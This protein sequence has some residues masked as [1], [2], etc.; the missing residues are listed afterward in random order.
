MSIPS[1]PASTSDRLQ[2][3]H[4]QPR[5]L[6]VSWSWSRQSG[7]KSELQYSQRPS[8]G[9]G[10]HKCSGGGGA[11]A[12]DFGVASASA[13]S[14]ADLPFLSR[15]PAY[16]ALAVRR[17]AFGAV[18]R[19]AAGSPL[20]SGLPCR[21]PCALGAH[22]HRPDAYKENPGGSTRRS[23]GS[24]HAPTRKRFRP[25]TA[26][27][28]ENAPL[29][30]RGGDFLRPVSNRGRRASHSRAYSLRAD[31]RRL[32]VREASEHVR[33]VFAFPMIAPSHAGAAPGLVR[34]SLRY[35][36][37]RRRG[38]RLDLKAVDPLIVVR[39]Q[40]ASDLSSNECDSRSSDHGAK[41]PRRRAS[42]CLG[43]E[44]ACQPAARPIARP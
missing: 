31:A 14:V 9:R 42:G 15:T 27:K 2:G 25:I 39:E 37:E 18:T 41:S 44:P 17:L 4:S 16:D 7:P 22:A 20:V 43:R 19:V 32:H 36:I 28:I 1:V 21:S 38:C 33:Q 24:Q 23:L 35:R 26:L 10:G 12:L 11:C 5:N 8:A 30:G 29:H 34:T 40:R 3:W 6:P 13:V